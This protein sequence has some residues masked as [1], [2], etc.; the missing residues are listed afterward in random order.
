[1]LQ[2]YGLQKFNLSSASVQSNLDTSHSLHALYTS[3][4]FEYF[5]GSSCLTNQEINSHTCTKRH[6]TQAV[7]RK[8][9]WS[10]V[11]ISRTKKEN[12][13]QGSP[14]QRSHMTGNDTFGPY[15]INKQTNLS[16]ILV[17]TRKVYSSLSDVINVSISIYNF[18]LVPS[19]FV[20]RQVSH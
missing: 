5:F 15:K 1:M 20:R 14:R 17:V 6:S 8:Y 4:G 10:L 7:L 2:Y 9:L 3:C 18:S 19:S 16:Q 13:H 11:Q 12:L